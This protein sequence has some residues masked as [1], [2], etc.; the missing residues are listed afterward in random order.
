MKTYDAIIIGSGVSGLSAAYGLKEA[1]KTVLVVEE[2]LWGGTCPNRGC[3][4]KK[5]LLSAVEA[6]NRV[7]QLSGKGFNE[8]PTANW[9]ELQKFKRT[10]T[11]PVPESRKKQLAE[12]E[13]DHLSGTARFLDDSSI[14]VNE[15]VFHADY[16]VLATGQRPTILPVEGKE[17]LKTSAD[18]LSLPV[19][20]KEIIFIGGGYIAF[21]LATIAN[22]AGSKVTIVH[23]NQRPLKEF[24]ASLV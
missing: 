21:E 20:P 13:I 1:G 6:R 3:D 18:F 17:Y 12:A 14:E 23:H 22:A 7:K 16:L 15:E 19:L 10:F 8:I 2:D 11:D 9:E 24:E 4:P 5:V